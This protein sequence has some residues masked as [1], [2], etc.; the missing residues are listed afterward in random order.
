MSSASD[1]GRMDYGKWRME[2]IQ[3]SRYRIS[4]DAETVRALIDRGNQLKREG[5]IR[6]YDEWT[7]FMWVLRNKYGEL[8][9]ETS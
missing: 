1:I 9:S 5:N 2:V 6:D 3:V 8:T 4:I 7:H